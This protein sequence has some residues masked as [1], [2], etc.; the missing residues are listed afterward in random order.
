MSGGLDPVAAIMAAITVLFGGAGIWTFLAARATAKADKEIADRQS[1]T[2]DWTSLMAYWQAEL[3]AV[4]Q[5]AT[6]LEVRVALLAQQRDDDLQF[7]ED[8]EQHIWQELPPP[9]PLRRRY[10]K[11]EEDP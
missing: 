2:A 7:I 9:P 3:S 4:R 11:S 10:R 6:N 8:L 5:A 1:N